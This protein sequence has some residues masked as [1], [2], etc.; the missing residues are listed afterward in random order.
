MVLL[1]YYTVLMLTYVFHMID[2]LSH[3]RKMKIF[4]KKIFQTTKHVF[5]L[6]IH[7]ALQ[8]CYTNFCDFA[9]IIQKLRAQ[10]IIIFVTVLNFLTNYSIRKSERSYLVLKLPF[11]RTLRNWSFKDMIHKALYCLK[12]Y[13]FDY[14]CVLWDFLLRK[15]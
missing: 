14:R 5:A 9:E 2:F 13:I 7:S 4:F 10:E 3:I 6:P 12:D 15:F 8:M 1:F 11:R